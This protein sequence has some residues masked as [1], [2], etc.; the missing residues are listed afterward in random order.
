MEAIEEEKGGIVEIER[1][2]LNHGTQENN[3]VCAG[4]CRRCARK[5]H[6][7]ADGPDAGQRFVCGMMAEAEHA[8][9][10]VGSCAHFA[11]SRSKII[12]AEAEQKRAL[13]HTLIT[14][15]QA[16]FMAGRRA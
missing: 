1:P 10:T 2:V 5:E 15:I 6:T 3:K 7:Q 4:I 13:T 16:A 8:G 9:I 12:D 11:F 14:G